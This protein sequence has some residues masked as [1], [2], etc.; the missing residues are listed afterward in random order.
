MQSD[1]RASRKTGGRFAVSGCS[2]PGAGIRQAFFVW[3]FR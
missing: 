3:F 1:E 2:K